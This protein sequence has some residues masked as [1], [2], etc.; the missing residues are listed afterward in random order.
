MK[1][2]NKAAIMVANQLDWLRFKLAEHNSVKAFAITWDGESETFQGTITMDAAPWIRSVL[3][4]QAHVQEMNQ[5]AYDAGVQEGAAHV[6]E[7]QAAAAGGGP[8]GKS[9]AN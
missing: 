9:N 8:G 2:E 7:Q 3:A 1:I 4:E 6:T 5:R